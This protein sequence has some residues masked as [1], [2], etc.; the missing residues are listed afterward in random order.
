MPRS[1]SDHSD[2]TRAAAIV[3]RVVRS[4]GFAGLRR[5]WRA[6]P[7]SEEAAV[8]IRIIEDCPWQTV[9]STVQQSGADRFMWA[10]D[11]RCDQDERSAQ[12]PDAQMSGPWLTLVEAVQ[13]FAAPARR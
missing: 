4:G 6:E 10:I 7:A 9:S 12:L 1:D 8:W 3:V 5:E 2:D 11:A 13:T